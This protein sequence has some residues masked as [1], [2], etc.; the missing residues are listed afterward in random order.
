M[1][2]PSL[3]PYAERVTQLASDK[4]SFDYWLGY[5]RPVPNSDLCWLV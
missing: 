3:S 1:F 5:F 2:S 4:R